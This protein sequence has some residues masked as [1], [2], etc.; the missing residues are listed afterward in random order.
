MLNNVLD[1]LWPVKRKKTGRGDMTG[2]CVGTDAAVF[3][4][5]FSIIN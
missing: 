4:N 1:R 2:I 5:Y 3:V